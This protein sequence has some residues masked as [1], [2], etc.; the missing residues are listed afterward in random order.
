MIDTQIT[1]YCSDMVAEVF[2]PAVA[3]YAKAL[4]DKYGIKHDEAMMIWDN[5][6]PDA[7]SISAI[8]SNSK[9]E[10]ADVKK[11][12]KKGAMYWESFTV[13]RLEWNRI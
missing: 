11:T 13:I 7:F 1:K 4:C 6:N 3:Q 2:R 5:M 8:K 12:K 9:I 10:K